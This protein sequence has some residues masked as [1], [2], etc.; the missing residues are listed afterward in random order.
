MK[1]SRQVRPSLPC[2]I[3]SLEAEDLGF[4]NENHRHSSSL[5]L[6]HFFVLWLLSCSVLSDSLWP[7]DCSPPGYSVH[8]IFQARMLV[9]IAVFLLRGIF[10]TWGMNPHILHCRQIL[11]PLSHSLKAIYFLSGP[12]HLVFLLPVPSTFS[13][14]SI[15]I[16]GPFFLPANF[17]SF[18]MLSLLH[19]F[20]DSSVGEESTCNAGDPSSIPGSRKSTGEGIGYPLQYSG[21]EN[22][23]DWIVH[24]VT[25]SPT[26]LRDFHFSLLH[27]F[28]CS[29]YDAE[30]W[31]LF[32]RIAS[33]RKNR[34]EK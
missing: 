12:A 1:K 11:Y 26:R 31:T 16:I 23:M 4:Q 5:S 14:K 27:S 9:W 29:T 24:G 33:E 32:L 30:R 17:T 15:K 22:S 18:A 7:F 20:P 6:S 19:G 21:L 13:W 10:L 34:G 25:K 2:L 3:I 28:C 8:R